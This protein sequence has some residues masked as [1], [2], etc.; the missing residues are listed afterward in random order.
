MN[1]TISQL[2]MVDS[3]HWYGHVWKREDG[4]IWRRASDLVVEGRRKNGK[5]KMTWKKQVEEEMVK[6]GL[7]TEHAL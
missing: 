5:A 4:H 3:L 7:V 2:A 6:A 1:E